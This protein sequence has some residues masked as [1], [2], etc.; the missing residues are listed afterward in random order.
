MTPE[1]RTAARDDAPP[2]GDELDEAGAD[3]PDRLLTADDD[4]AVEAPEDE[5]PPHGDVLADGA[6]SLGDPEG[7]RDEYLDQLRRV[8]A[9]FENY[10]KRVVK[11]QTEHLE[12]AAEELV[13]KLLPV[14]DAGESARKHGVEEA[15]PVYGA[16]L[17][18]L[19]KEGLARVDPEGEAFDPNLH[20]AVAH[21]PAGEDDE[22]TG[23]VVEVLR[24]GYLW[25]G[26]VLRP[27]LVKVKG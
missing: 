27:A 3:D 11:Q 25:K 16:L 24:A 19:E 23:R 9:E 18:I 1:R 13:S 4:H 22:D 20:E 2:H 26:R 7:E 5:A 8:Q 12:R 14:L 15:E 17:A 10:R 6:A 21:E